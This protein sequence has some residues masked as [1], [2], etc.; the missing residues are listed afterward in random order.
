ME[1]WG[2]GRLRWGERLGV[3]IGVGCR[4][5]LASRKNFSCISF[6]GMSDWLDVGVCARVFIH[7]RGSEKDV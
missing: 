7:F 2:G 5:P 1:G 6:W 4:V 3:R